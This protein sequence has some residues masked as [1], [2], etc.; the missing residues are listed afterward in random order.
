MALT[1]EEAELVRSSFRIVSQES[2]QAAARFY[3]ILFELAPETRSLFLNDMER[4]GAMLMSKLGL[5]VAEIQNLEG[6]IPV[7]EDLALR[8][9]AYGVKPEDYQLV[10][11]ALLQ[12]LAEVLGDDFTPE[13][14]AAWTKAYDDLSETMINSAYSYRK[15]PAI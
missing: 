10:S 2:G 4:Q 5:V 8:H 11:T 1:S 14:K 6:L 12:M 7:L 15:I 3:Q 13:M 9:V